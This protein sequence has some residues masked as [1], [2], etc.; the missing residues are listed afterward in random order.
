M[1]APGTPDYDEQARELAPDGPGWDT[2]AAEIASALRA[3]HAAGLREGGAVS[4][5]WLYERDVDC[6]WVGVRKAC[7]ARAEEVESS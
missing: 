5:R 6:Y 7:E 3:A 1:A 2:L 4:E